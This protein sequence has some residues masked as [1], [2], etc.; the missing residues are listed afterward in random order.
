MFFPLMGGFIRMGIIVA[1]V[2]FVTQKCSAFPFHKGKYAESF[3]YSLLDSVLRGCIKNGYLY[4]S[5]VDTAL[6]GEFIS[7]LANA[8][9]DTFRLSEDRIVFFLNAYTACLIQG[10]IRRPGL[11]LDIFSS[12][13][14]AD[15]IFIAQKFYTLD[16]LRIYCTT[17]NWAGQ[18]LIF[19][20][21]GDF[22][23]SSAALPNKAWTAQAVI[24]NLKESARRYFKNKENG[25]A[26]DLRSHTLRVPAALAQFTGYFSNDNRPSQ[27][28]AV[29]LLRLIAEFCPPEL[30]AFI[31]I[32]KDSMQILIA[33][34][35]NRLRIRYSRGILKD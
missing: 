20:G 18:Q 28:R 8:Q 22:T 26:A 29:K 30:S 17:F 10:I 15:S 24:N 19:F 16:M 11:S 14:W 2:C 9:P 23:L 5:S 33:E 21:L 34:N 6:L 32:Y 3:S 27:E 4:P 1:A 12:G 13:I 25:F 35:D 7:S 31:A